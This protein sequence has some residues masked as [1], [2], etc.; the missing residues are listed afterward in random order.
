MK[1]ATELLKACFAAIRNT[2][3]LVVRICNRAVMFTNEIR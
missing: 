1:N 3:I 2:V